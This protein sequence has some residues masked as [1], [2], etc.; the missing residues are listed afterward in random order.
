MRSIANA[1]SCAVDAMLDRRHTGGINR[2]GNVDRR[3][4]VA[5]SMF[6][7]YA[8]GRCKRLALAES[9]PA[10]KQPEPKNA[11]EIARVRWLMGSP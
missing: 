3:K 9:A 1:R 4:M 11:P 8:D 10:A 7:W 6:H 5:R 2:I